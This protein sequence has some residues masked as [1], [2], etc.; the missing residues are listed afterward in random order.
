MNNELL[1]VIFT[2][3]RPMILAESWRT[4]FANNKIKPNR[5]LVIDDGSNSEVKH[6]LYNAQLNTSDVPLD[7]Y[8]IGK[9]V[10]YGVAAELAFN[11]VDVYNP[12]YVFFIESD[13]I[14]AKNGLDKVI[15]IFKNTEIGKNAVAFSGY[16][17]PDFYVKEKT[18]ETFPRIIV[19]D[20]GSDNLNRSIMYKPFK[21]S[22]AFGEVDLEFV[23][24][25]CGT[26]YFNWEM[27]CSLR[28]F[29]PNLYK[30]WIDKVTDKSKE[31]RLLND[32]AMSHGISWIWNEYAKTQGIDRDKY[33]ALLNIKPSVADHINGAGINGHIVGEGQ[34]F[35]RSPS[36]KND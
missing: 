22:T 10:G 1:Y 19:E 16:D 36:W 34:S 28:N 4:L 20:C 33:A 2:H 21:Q 8:S 24:N 12:K 15:D 32:G 6:G 13:Y 23:S 7:L 18:D 30:T 27:I 5:V 31:R 26:M 14:F 3:N 17:N 9:N 11:I 29:R 35:V 25:S